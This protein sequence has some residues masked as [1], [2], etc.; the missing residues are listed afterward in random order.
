[1][2]AE[3]FFASPHPPASRFGPG[4]VH[5]GASVGRRWRRAS[6]RQATADWEWR[7][8]SSKRRDLGM[9]MGYG[10]VPPRHSSL[11]RAISTRS[12]RR[13]VRQPIGLAQNPVAAEAE[14]CIGGLRTQIVR[15]A[16]EMEA[17]GAKRL[18]RLVEHEA[19][20]RG[21]DSLARASHGDAL[22]IEVAMRVVE[23]GQDG[24]GERLA[25]GPRP[26]AGRPSR[27]KRASRGAPPP[28]SGRPSARSPACA[29]AP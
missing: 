23:A 6:F 4:P 21:P 7:R 9:E 8:A 20:E 16:V 17:P 3:D 10:P 2:S 24:E 14:F 29:R 28:S 11:R 27:A 1:M 12:V 22:Q 13:P 18:E 5:A 26:R 19:E 15:E 25:L